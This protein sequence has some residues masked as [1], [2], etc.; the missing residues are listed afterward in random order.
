MAY[1]DTIKPGALRGWREEQVLA[2][3]IGAQA[4]LESGWG[5][6]SLS[7]PPHNNQFGIKASSEWTGRIINMP[8]RE[9][10]SGGWYVAN[11]DFRSYDSV[12]DS[13]LDHAKF[14][15]NTAWRKENYKNVVGETDYKKACWALQNAPAPYAT[16]PGYAQKLIDI[17]EQNNL[18]AW[19]REATSDQSTETVATTPTQ[20]NRTKMVG[21]DLTAAAR[22]YVVNLPVTVIGDSLGVGTRPHLQS[23]ITTANFDVLGSRQITHATPSLNGTK[24]LTDMKNAGTLKEYVV[25]ILGTNRGVT[26]QEVNNFVSIAGSERKVIFVDTASQVAHADQVSIY[27]TDAAKRLS[28]VFYVNW[29][30]KASSHMADYYSKDG[31]NGEYI[32]M[33]S[34]G[35]KKHAEFIA[36]ALYEVATGDFT[37]R[38]AVTPEIDY[39]NIKTLE[40]KTDGTITYDAW[41]INSDG[42]STKYKA[43]KQT[44]IKGLSSPYGDDSIY[45]GEANQQW[46]FGGSVNNSNWLESRYTDNDETDML[47]LVEMASVELLD[48]ATPDIQYT[49]SLM[50]MPDTISIGDTGVFVDHDF[51]PPLYIQARIISITTSQTNPMLNKVVIGNVIELQPQ[52]KN[53]ILAMQEELRRTREELKDEWINAEPVSASI[54]TTNGYVLGDK[55][56]ETDLVAKVVKAGVNVTDQ[57]TSFKW[58]RNSPDSASDTVYNQVLQETT[59]SSVLSVTAKDII[60][61]QSKFTAR[62]YNAKDEM[63]HQTEITIKRVETALWTDTDT[64]PVDAKDGATWT[65]PDGTQ[66]VK[67]DGVWEERVDQETISAVRLEVEGAMTEAEQAKANA[68]TARN[69]AVAEAERLVLE[70]N[71]VWQGVMAGYDEQVGFIETGVSE[72]KAKADQALLDVGVSTDLAQTAK[73]L[74]DTALSNAQAALGQVGTLSPLVQN[75]VTDASNAVTSSNTA[76]AN[77]QTAL[78]EAG[79]AKT[80][81]NGLVVRVDEVEGELELKANQTVVNGLSGIVSSQGTLIT[82]NAMA[83]TNKAESSLV[84][85]IKDTVDTHT[86]E[87]SQ[88]AIAL[89]QRFTKTEVNN[90]LS[91]KANTS[92]LTGLATQTW[93]NTQ[94]STSASGITAEI[95]RVESSIPSLNGYATQTWSNTQINVKADEVTQLITD[96]KTNPTGTITGFNQLKNN[97]DSMVQTIGTDGSKIAQMVLTNSAYQTTISDLEL[98]A[99][100]GLGKQMRDDPTFLK[101]LNGATVYNNSANGNVV[102]LREFGPG[103]GQPTESD[104]RLKITTT[105]VASPGHGGFLVST[106]SRANAQFVVRFTALVPIGRTIEIANNSIGTG[107]KITW[108]TSREGTG[109]WV[110]YSY[111]VECGSSGTFSTFGFQYLSG[112]AVPTPQAPL[113]WYVA[114][115]EIID[116]G[117]SQQSQITQLADSWSLT[118]KSGDDVKT[119]INATTNA[120]RL[121]AD[122]IHLSGLSLIDNAVI[123]SAH[124]DT[125][126]ANKVTGNSADFNAIRTGI[127]TANAVTSAHISADN[128]LIDKLFAN[129]ALID[130]LTSKTAFI[131]QL[132]AIDLIA[133]KATLVS[134]GFQ[135]LNSNMQIDGSQIKITNAANDYA[136]MNA[137]PEFRSQDSAGTAA[138]MGKG[139]THYY[140]GGI[141]RFYEGTNLDDSTKHGVNIAKSQ[142]WGIYRNSDS[143]GGEPAQYYTVRAGEQRVAVITRLIQLGHLPDGDGN[144]F[145]YLCNMVGALNGWPSISVK[146]WPTLQAGDMVMWKAAILG[147]SSGIERIWTMGTATNGTTRVYSHVYHVFEAGTSLSSDRRIKHDIEESQVKALDHIN[148][149]AFKRYRMNRDNSII[150]LGLIAQDSGILRVQDDETEGIDLQGSIML[151][152]KGTQELYAIVQAQAEEIKKLKELIN[153]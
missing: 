37:E 71:Q 41:K 93:T 96:V 15:T 38:T 26:E 14:F 48:R 58:E 13:L 120:I 147:N 24:V 101:G 134:A 122:L 113:N 80:I 81:A 44:E 9:W 39:Y 59:Q 141:P 3:V 90:L 107:G 30:L 85:T 146:E 27:Y 73:N 52:S 21:A 153:Q 42:T 111:L 99:K 56:N 4:A 62:V 2:S 6:S 151:A 63:V 7:K 87:I 33:T 28:N 139:R 145:V 88:N 20:V 12:A 128:A 31:A 47:K 148:S 74:S 95:S 53:E 16:D 103:W 126:N 70:Q 67:K 130:R 110:E 89:T 22:E 36:Q 83:I 5:T 32:H 78:T 46:G 1:L 65:K 100:F 18:Q 121:K 43:T 106:L 105:G 102:I 94:I 135:A 108:M 92:A 77:A 19:D 144:H 119:S 25:V 140:S 79:N 114:K 97:V 133:D 75:A 35:Y 150:E 129:S 86:S 109:K 123:K 137:I 68:I 115:Y 98:K 152:L 76:L 82:Q 69:E 104:Y 49:V 127:L 29:K 60:G 136:T 138:I 8:T 17:I 11:E 116:V 112:G 51:N 45:N 57:Y 34:A 142:T 55:F 61:N 149:L 84:N 118:L 132:K 64:P 40:L 91:S 50:D 117:S 131:S 54:T 23:I 143:Y 124:I 72:A 10:G 125:L 66:W